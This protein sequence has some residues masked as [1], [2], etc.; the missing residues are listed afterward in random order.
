MDISKEKRVRDVM[1][2][3]VITVSHDTPVSKIVKLLVDEDISG[4]AVTAPDD[5]IVGVISEI[6]I[7]KVF[8][9]DWE[10]ATAEDV[11]STFVRSIDPETS[12]RKAAGIMKELNIHRLLILSVSPAKGIPIAILTASDILKASVQ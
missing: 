8:D 12:L 5:E 11:M 7:V 9:K 10:S 6:D 1:T 4:V 2:R 3:G